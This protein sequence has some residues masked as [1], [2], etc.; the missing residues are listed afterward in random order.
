M[1]E[2]WSAAQLLRGHACHLLPQLRACGDFRKPIAFQVLSQ[3]TKHPQGDRAAGSLESV[4]YRKA[5][6]TGRV[7]FQPYRVRE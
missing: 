1:E 2:Q 3:L 4:R 6:N 5:P 7:P